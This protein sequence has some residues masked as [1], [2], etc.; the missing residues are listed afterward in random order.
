[1][2]KWMQDNIS[3]MRGRLYVEEKK[4][5]KDRYGLMNFKHDE[6]I[7]DDAMTYAGMSNYTSTSYKEE[8]QSYNNNL[9][10][11]SKKDQNEYKSSGLSSSRTYTNVR[12]KTGTIDFSK[13]SLEK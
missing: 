9:I 7:S 10:D 2:L 1:M 13:K 4:Q 12:E 8:D 5:D 3:S 6:K 11:F